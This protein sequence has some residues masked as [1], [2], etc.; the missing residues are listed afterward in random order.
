MR[1]FVLAGSLALLLLAACTQETPMSTATPTVLF[2]ES[3]LVQQHD[4]LATV[5]I[6]Q[7]VEKTREQEEPSPIGSI[8]CP[9]TIRYGFWRVKVERYL[10]NP[11]PYDEITYKAIVSVTR[12]DGRPAARLGT[13]SPLPRD[14]ERVVFFLKRRI[15]GLYPLLTGDTYGGSQAIKLIEDGLVDV[16]P[17]GGQHDP[18]WVP[19]DEFVDFIVAMAGQPA[20]PEEPG[21]QG[22]GPPLTATP[23]PRGG[24]E[25][26]IADVPE[27]AAREA[28]R[29]MEQAGPGEVVP[30]F[31][32]LFLDA[33]DNSIVYVYML[34]ASQ[35]EAAEQA[36]RII[37]D[38]ERIAE[39]RV[40]QGDYSWGQLLGWYREA[41]RVLWPIDHVFSSDIDEMRNRI[42]FRVGTSY[43]AQQAREA[44]AKTSVPNQAVV[45]QVSSKNRL[46]DPPVQIESL[47]GVSISLEF[48]RSVPVE[49]PIS[50]EVV[51]TNESGNPVEFDH[52]NPF[53][54]NVMIFTASGDQVWAKEIR[55]QALVGTGDSTRLES[56]EQVR[57]QTLWD[58]R[59][60]DGFELPAGRYLVRG[61]VQISDNPAGFYRAMD[62]ATE[63]YELVII[64][65]LTPQPAPRPLLPGRW[66]GP[67]IVDLPC[68]PGVETGKAYSFTLYTH[69]GIHRAYFDGRHWIIDPVFSNDNIN[70]PPG[71]GNPIDEG[72]MELAADDLARYTSESG[73]AAEFRPLPE[74]EEDVWSCD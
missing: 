64:P 56:D 60:Q 9:C 59:D 50:I 28:L 19:L 49:R 69:C 20:V 8:G 3:A 51:L 42:A 43:A 27:P 12:S 34:D 5:I 68:G 36:A 15:T 39:V 7:V 65:Q 53:H 1:Y 14:G 55:G 17:Y 46:D 6:G 41:Q 24:S 38:Y 71:W 44:L 57:L 35:Q 70:P 18:E 2:E 40:L 23:P 74:G 61:T 11:Q 25:P 30:G 62:L 26:N 29:R 72:T 47:I 52:G 45:F 4:G 73:M 37:L 67:G 54:E 48:E 13:R 10:A 22:A 63:P 21:W 16:A 33:S 58:Q 31:G 66:C 32:G